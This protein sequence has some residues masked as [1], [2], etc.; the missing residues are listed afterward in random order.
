M[1]KIFDL[2]EAFDGF[3]AGP[4]R[5]AQILAGFFRNNIISIFAFYYHKKI[6]ALFP[7]PY[8]N[9]AKE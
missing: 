4:I 8:K 9:W 6:I 7:V 5:P 2:L 1:L 3:R